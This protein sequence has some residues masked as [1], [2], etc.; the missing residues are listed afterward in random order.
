MIPLV[1]AFQRRI[2]RLNKRVQKSEDRFITW[3]GKHLWTGELHGTPDY[4]L[5]MNRRW[6][7]GPS[8][9]LFETG[10]EIGFGRYLIQY[11]GKP[12]VPPVLVAHG[13]I[14]FRPFE[15]KL[16]QE[17][18]YYDGPHCLYMFGPVW[19]NRSW[20]TLCK[21]CSPEDICTIS[22]STPKEPTSMN[23]VSMK[24]TLS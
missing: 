16:E 5:K 13:G 10:F 7:C 24:E 6:V 18:I 1:E 21:K 19:F 17:H 12:C 3:L 8:I 14:Q 2:T 23:D 11:E 4:I 9:W 15:W 20:W 22:P